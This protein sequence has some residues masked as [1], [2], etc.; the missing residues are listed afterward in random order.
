MTGPIL[1]RLLWQMMLQRI[2]KTYLS[3]KKKTFVLEKVSFFLLYPDEVK[4]TASLL[5]K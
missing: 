2:R 3:L 4:S 1:M 5:N